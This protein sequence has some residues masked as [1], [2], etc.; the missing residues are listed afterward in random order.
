MVRIATTNYAGSVD[1]T[2]EWATVGTDRFSRLLDLYK[3][4]QALELHTHAASKGL[5]VERVANGSIGTAQIAAGAV[6][7][8]KLATD[9]VTAIAVALDAIGALELANGS[10]DTAAIIDL[11]VTTQ[12]LAD[13]AVT[14]QKLADLAVT[15]AKMADLNVTTAKI[16]NLA[17]TAG[18]LAAGVAV[19]NLGYTP[20]NKLGDSMTGQLS[21][22]RT[23]GAIPTA[24]SVAPLVVQSLDA[25]AN[26]A[27]TAGI[28]FHRSN[29]SGVYLYHAGLTAADWLRFIT[30]AGGVA[31]VFS[32]LNMGAGSGLD[33][34]SLLTKVPTATPTI[35]AIPLA[36][37]AG[38]LDSWVT[39]TAGIPTG[40]GCWV[41]TAAE[42]PSGFSRETNLDGRIPVGA[43]LTFGVTY[44]EA[45]NYGTAWSFTPTDSGHSHGGS[46]LGVSGN[47]GGPTGTGTYGG[48][49]STAA[50]GSHTHNQGTL[51]VTGTTDSGSAVMTATTWT[52]PSR[53][54][55]WARKN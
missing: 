9:S 37:G 49:G 41:R 39:A 28:G 20:V 19:A 29:A 35:G 10:V 1:T 22:F 50:D 32:T 46:A 6:D 18:K 24:F 15:A 52:I 54:V 13:L 16:A 55:V 8:T 44:V 40:L 42:I 25:L 38:K 17:V 47:T 11:A 7:A 45:T 48:T 14:T 53:G 4:A 30:H 3:L 36:D 12:K 34:A 2:F 31:S 23:Q 5:A 26:P 51:D 21:I 27:E 43:G 33:A